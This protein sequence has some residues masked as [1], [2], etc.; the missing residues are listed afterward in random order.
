MERATTNI[1]HPH[2]ASADLAARLR[3]ELVATLRR[4][5]PDTPGHSRRVAENVAAIATELG[6]SP[7]RV[8]RLRLAGLLHDVGKV[9]TPAAILEKPGPLTES[10]FAIVKRHSE[11]GAAMVAALGEPEL[12]AVVRHH[13]ERIDGRGYPAG[14]AAAEIPLGARIVAVADTFDAVTSS[15]PYR[16]AIGEDEALELLD[17]EAGTQ[18]DP[19]VVTVFQRCYARRR[20]VRQ[21]LLSRRGPSIAAPIRLAPG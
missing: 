16:P 18:L 20:S 2:P 8:E 7:Q 9:H 12:T 14:L 15:R 1:P 17:R 11:I 10:E 21:V 13:H 5:G 3:D 6:A 4:G 19:R